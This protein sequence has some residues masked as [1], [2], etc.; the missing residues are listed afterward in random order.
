[1]NAIAFPFAFKEG[2]GTSAQVSGGTD[3]QKYSLYMKNIIVAATSAKRQ[4]P[5]DE[6]V[7]ITNREPLPFCR[8]AFDKAG[9]K[10][11]IIPYDSFTMPGNF[12]WSLAF[13]KLC[14][15]AYLAK[16]DY[17]KVV[18]LDA[19]TLSV[20]SYE[21]MWKE[22]EDGLLLY[23]VGHSY[24]HTEREVIRKD[25]VQLGFDHL[26][27][28]VHYGGEFVCGKV[29]DFAKYVAH[30]QEVFVRVEEKCSELRDTFND[31]TI[32]CIAAMLYRQHDRIIDAAAY[33]YRFWT[34]KGF[35]L[36]ETTWKHQPVTIWHLPGEKTTGILEL[37]KY[38]QKHGDYPIIEKSAKMLGLLPAKR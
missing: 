33:S 8:E 2:Y 3:E 29:S 5:E 35:Y 27:N 9:I 32:F 25:T 30:C 37:Y 22:A 28:M 1:M 23:P 38:Y 14:A 18:V 10:I 11:T 13:F 26:G 19:D 24:H 7:M 21:E 17:E 20:R 16:S 31:E 12:P 15:M 36:V 6:V 34:V 4:N